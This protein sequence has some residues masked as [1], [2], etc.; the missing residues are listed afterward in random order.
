V[1]GTVSEDI[2]KDSPYKPDAFIGKPYSTVALARF[3]AEL[4]GRD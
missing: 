1:S 3:V 2:Y 4:T